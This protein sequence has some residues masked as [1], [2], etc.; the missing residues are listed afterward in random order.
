MMKCSIKT[1]YETSKKKIYKLQTNEIF[2]FEFVCPTN[3]SSMLLLY[4]KIQKKKKKKEKLDWAT[5]N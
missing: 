5:K 2:T 3:Y 1:N 4:M